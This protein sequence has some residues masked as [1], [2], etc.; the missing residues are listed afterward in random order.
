MSTCGC[1]EHVVARAIAATLHTDPRIMCSMSKFWTWQSLPASR[2]SRHTQLEESEDGTM[3]RP[4]KESYD[5]GSNAIRSEQARDRL[6]CCCVV[7]SS[8]SRGNANPDGA[9]LK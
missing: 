5:W 3:I 7:L 1:R 4:M 2:T 9:K 6:S 8:W